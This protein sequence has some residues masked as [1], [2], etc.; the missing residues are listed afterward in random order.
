MT[1]TAVLGGNG[2]DDLIQMQDREN[3]LQTWCNE[4]MAVLQALDDNDDDQNDQA[5]SAG[6]SDSSMDVNENT[7]SNPAPRLS[8][9]GTHTDSAKAW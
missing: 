6:G 3:I 7:K 2:I 9:E 1:S 4:Q 5:D 8:S